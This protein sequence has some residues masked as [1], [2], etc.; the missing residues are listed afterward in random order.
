M[1]RRVI[2]SPL[3][4]APC[5]VI[6]RG[7]TDIRQDQPRPRTVMRRKHR[8]NAEL[9]TA[10]WT[11]PT[12]STA[13]TLMSLNVR[14]SCHQIAGPTVQWTKH[15]SLKTIVYT[16]RQLS[17]RSDQS[18]HRSRDTPLLASLLRL[19]VLTSLLSQST[20]HVA[21]AK[22]ARIR[23]QLAVPRAS[24]QTQCRARSP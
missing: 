4:K 21:H 1:T 11:P 23:S 10:A 6:G 9:P 8:E 19:R 14:V 15:I 18:I 17:S 22:D 12:N 3:I 5:C 16:L 20:A 2:T 13:E 24:T 7:V